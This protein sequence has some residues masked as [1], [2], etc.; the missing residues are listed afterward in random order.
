MM[1]G[2]LIQVLTQLWLH[3]HDVS[4]SALATAVVMLGVV[5][6]LELRSVVQLRHVTDKQLGRVFEQLD[7]LRFETQR[8]LECQEAPVTP[9]AAMRPAVRPRPVAPTVALPVADSVATTATRS[10]PVIPDAPLPA[11]PT[12]ELV[13]RHVLS[14]GEA[15]LLSSLAQARARRAVAEPALP[16]LPARA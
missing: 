16:A 12:R 13:D 3:V 4:V 2:K 11:A 5:V 1:E 10:A 6:L 15:R 8:L 9:A 7:L 14:S